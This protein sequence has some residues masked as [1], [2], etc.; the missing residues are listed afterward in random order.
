MK[1]IYNFM[2]KINIDIYYNEYEFILNILI[3]IISFIFLL[4][5]ILVCWTFSIY[6]NENKRNEIQRNNIRNVINVH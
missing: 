6:R 2:I 5:N 3:I 1:Y 4:M